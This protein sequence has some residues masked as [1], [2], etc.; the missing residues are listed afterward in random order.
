M[1]LGPRF[2]PGD[3][4]THHR[5]YNEAGKAIRCAPPKARTFFGGMSGWGDLDID[6]SVPRGPQRWRA[7]LTAPGERAA[8]G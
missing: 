1:R 5:A 7:R 3:A 4:A 2:A 8:A 6:R